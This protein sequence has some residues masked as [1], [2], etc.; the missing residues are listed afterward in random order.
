MRILLAAAALLLAAG[1]SAADP[2]VQLGLRLA[3]APAVGSAAAS[4]PMSE[5]V[6][7]HV[8]IQAEAAWSAGGF[9]AGGYASWGPGQVGAQGCGDGASCSAQ[10]I[11]AGAQALWTFPRTRYGF[12]PWTGGGL[13]WEWASHR[14]ERLGAATTTSW[15]GPEL[16]VQGG[17]AWRVADRFAVGPFLLVG[18]GWYERVAIETPEA[19]GSGSIADR[20]VHV[21]F[22]L[23]VRGTVEL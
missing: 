13:G 22:H 8:P 10:V 7:W 19:F 15:N 14:R 1:A 2:A 18:L 4:V 5:A 6:Q 17:A 9:A 20:A 21:W 12:A 11:R 23:G 3:W 16:G